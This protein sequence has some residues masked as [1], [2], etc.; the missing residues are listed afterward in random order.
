M[1][2]Q[3]RQGYKIMLCILSRI[4]GSTKP[5]FFG[6]GMEKLLAIRSIPWVSTW[7][8]FLKGNEFKNGC[9]CQLL[10]KVCA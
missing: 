10:A 6:T 2:P 5:L 1:D 8:R 4:L 7:T 9:C 3:I